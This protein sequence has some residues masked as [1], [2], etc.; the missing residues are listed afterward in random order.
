MDFQK[1]LEHICSRPEMYVAEHRF[2]TV[3]AWPDGYSDG[4]NQG[5]GSDAEPAARRPFV[6]QQSSK[7][8]QP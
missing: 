2:R 3:A 5:R 8:F 7:Y 4:L 6:L 1:L